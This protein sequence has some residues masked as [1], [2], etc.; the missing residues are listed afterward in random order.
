[1]RIIKFSLWAPRIYTTDGFVR[2]NIIGD[3]RALDLGCGG[4]KLPGARGV[5]SLALPGVDVIHD[6]SIFQK[7]YKLS[8][9]ILRPVSVASLSGQ[10]PYMGV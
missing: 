4:R 10:V 9:N 7:V 8:H 5:D 2:Q 6:L 1:M 3:V